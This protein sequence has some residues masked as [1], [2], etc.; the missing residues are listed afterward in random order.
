[1]PAGG[2][3]A[4]R[5]DHREGHQ[6]VQ[7]LC[8]QH[9]GH[10][11]QQA[12]QRHRQ[13]PGA[14]KPARGLELGREHH[15]V[16]AD[17]RIGADLCHDAEKRGDGRGR[18]G[19]ARWQPE[20]QRRHSRLD[21][22]DHEQQHR[23]DADAG[24]V[25][26]V[27][28]GHADRKVGH[29][30][31]AG[32]GIDGAQREEEQRRAQQ[33]VEH[34]LRARPKPR[35]AAGVDHQPVGGDQQHLEEDKEVEDV[36]GQERPHDAHQLELVERVEMLPAFVP[37]GSDGVQQHQHRQH[38]GQQDH[39]RRQPVGDQH[40]AEGRG[41]VAELV[42]PDAAVRHLPGE[43]RADPQQRQRARDRKD[44][45]KVDVESHDQHDEGGQHR[46]Q[47]DGRD[48]PVGHGVP[49]S[50]GASLTWSSSLP[51]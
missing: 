49:S 15:R 5:P 51:R 39:H 8:P 36:A 40:D 32:F 22:E 17:D 24:A 50:S 31:C 25:R 34:V 6:P 18:L 27:D 20:V 45:R 46:G 23:R 47:D 9:A 21:R 44:P 43:P 19:I 35:V 2:K 38:R 42:E 30:E 11:D 41:P 37:P 7:P 14:E 16:D 13:Q 28:L 1:M 33:V 26:R 10:A 4:H 3:S 12:D 48:D 29:V